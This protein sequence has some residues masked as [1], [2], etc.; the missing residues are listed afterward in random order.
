MLKFQ[1]QKPR[2]FQ[3]L[4]LLMFWIC[5]PTYPN[6][7]EIQCCNNNGGSISCQSFDMAKVNIGSF[8]FKSF[9][10]KKIQTSKNCNSANVEI[11][12]R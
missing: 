11:N 6:Y 8:L 12:G 7:N 3:P 10:P 4:Y 1:K 9:I 2:I 5:N